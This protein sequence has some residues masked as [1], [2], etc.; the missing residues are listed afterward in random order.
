MGTAVKRLEELM[1]MAKANLR[2]DGYLVPALFVEAREPLLM[3]LRELP[4]TSE[5]R[6][7]MCYAI[8]HQLAPRRPRKVLSILDAYMRTG[9]ELPLQRSLADDP[10]AEECIVVAAMDRRGKQA[11]LI[12]PYVRTPRLEGTEFEFREPLDGFDGAEVYLLAAFW[13]GVAS[14]R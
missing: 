4:A 5:G 1:E 13:D 11:V 2:R 14:G 8:G 3:G 12:C 10:A 9:G 7:A 6:R